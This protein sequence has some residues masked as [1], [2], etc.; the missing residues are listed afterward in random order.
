V[1]TSD[2][3]YPTGDLGYVENGQVYFRAR[4]SEMIKTKGANVAPAEVEA[5]LKSFPEVRTT[6]VAG[7]PHQQYGQ[8]VAA[9]IVP[10]EGHTV[11]VEKLRAVMRTQISP[12][13]VPTVFLIVADDE[14]PYLASSKI[15][16][17]RVAAMLAHYQESRLASMP[18]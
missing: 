12:Y 4:L 6:I 16:R 5:L 1:F 14:L 3:F 18:S 9:A 2:G 13:K 11:D 15:D 10:E 8:E 7:V 17:R